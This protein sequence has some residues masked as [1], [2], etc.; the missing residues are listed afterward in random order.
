ML[1]SFLGYLCL[2]AFAW[3][4]SSS[5][6]HIRWRTIA[7][8]SAI[9]FGFGLLVLY[10]PAGKAALGWLSSAAIAGMLIQ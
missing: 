1:I 3:L 6:K 7:G 10:V 5:R 8:A 9:Q 4:C 2:I